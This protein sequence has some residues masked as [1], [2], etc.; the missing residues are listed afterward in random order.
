MEGWAGPSWGGGE[1]LEAVGY[2][3]DVLGVDFNVPFVGV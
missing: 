2:F 1:G 3:K